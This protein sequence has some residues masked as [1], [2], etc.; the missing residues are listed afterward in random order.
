MKLSRICFAFVILILLNFNSIAQ[1]REDLLPKSSIFSAKLFP[2]PASQV[3]S[4]DITSAVDLDKRDDKLGHMPKF[5]R[6]IATDIGLSN[7]GTWT[8]LPNG[9]RTWR[10]MIS[11][12]GALGLIPCYD[13][14]FIPLGATL[15]VYTPQ[16]D[17][18]I[19]AFV[20]GNNPADGHYNTGLIHG[21]VCVVEYYEPAAVSGMGRLHINEVGYAYRMVPGRKASRDFGDS[22]PCEVNVNCS[23]GNN[24]QDQKNAVVRILVKTGSNFGWCSGTIVNNTSQD[25]TPY[26]LS[27]DHCYQDETNNYVSATT[28][29]LNQWIFYFNYEAPGCANPSAQGSLGNHFLTGCSFRA[30]SL[31]N[32]GDNGSDFVLIKA[33][34]SIPLSYNPYYAGWS[35]LTTPSHAGV[36]IHHPNADIKKIS[37]YSTTLISS[38]WGNTVS[39]THWQVQWA[40]TLNGDGVTE[41]GSSG[42]PIFDLNKHVVG[43]LTGGGS[44]CSTPQINDFYGQIAYDWSSNGATANKRLQDWLDPGATGAQTFDGQYAPCSPT[45]SFDAGVLS[46]QPSSTVCDQSVI[47]TATLENFGNQ[48]L[49]SDSLTFTIDGGS[50]QVL[51]WTGALDPLMS[52]QV[53]LPAQNF[54]PG[55]HTYTV[56]SSSPDG[57]T[58]GNTA[59]DSKST[60][61][62]VI[63]APNH[64]TYTLETGDR[65]S[66]ISWELIDANNTIVYSGGPYSNS[67]SGQTI[68]QSWCLPTACYTFHI[69]N[70]AGH[71]L[72]GASLDGTYSIINNVNATVASLQNVN[73]GTEE[74]S[75]SICSSATTAVE[76]VSVSLASITI[77]PNPS[78]GIF[79]LS[80]VRQ[81]VSLTVTDALGRLIVSA[82]IKA[83]QS[84]QIDMGAGDSGVYL[85]HVTGDQGSLTKKIILTKGR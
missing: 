3:L 80:N 71:G 16:R 36:S 58:D 15:H 46:V 47:L 12:P 81:D 53:S 17:E 11:A 62:T 73:F 52:M 38:Q 1:V 61:F 42:S 31:D 85:I 65:G 39:N 26:I 69:F 82:D 22:S 7:S 19:G 29:D 48:Q 21:N 44:D 10:I 51:L 60:T 78:T 33:N 70:S 5:A 72:K 18:M 75:G 8:T 25:C 34:G 23:E 24:W 50:Q 57:N 84:S 27:A 30:A 56:A 6:A 63:G 49:N 28:S 54:S 76:D 13:A 66:E 74:S 45:L 67:S 2:A 79:T 9:D 83:G 77:W 43:T 32:G 20:S 14:F 68:T 4:F 37:T 59:N 40:P 55:V 64:Y 41:P 35:N